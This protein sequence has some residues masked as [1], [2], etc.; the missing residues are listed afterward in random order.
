MGGVLLVKRLLRACEKY[1]NTWYNAHIMKIIVP[2]IKDVLNI[3][4]VQRY[5]PCVSYRPITF[6]VNNIIKEGMLLYNTLT[7]SIILVEYNENVHR[8]LIENWFFVP[9]DFDD[10]RFADRVRYCLRNNQKKEIITTYTIYPTTN[11]NAK[12]SYCFENGRTKVNMSKET[13][14]KVAKFIAQKSVGYNLSFRWF[15]GEPLLNQMAIDTICEALRRKNIIY[16]SKMATNGFLFEMSSIDKAVNLW[17]LKQVQITLDGTKEK[18]NKTKRYNVNTDA[19]EKVINNIQLLAQNGIS[20]NIRLNVDIVNIDDQI[21][22][23]TGVL[24]NFKKINNMISIYSHLL[25]DSLLNI[26]AKERRILLIKKNLIESEIADL[27]LTTHK[28]IQKGPKIFKCIADNKKSYTIMPMGQ[29][30]LCEHYTED[31]FISDINHSNVV[32]EHEIEN[33]RRYCNIMNLCHNCA[34]YPLCIRL[35]LCPD[36][37]YCFEELKRHNIHNIKI[38]MFNE[39]ERYTHSCKSI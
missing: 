6:L 21:S 29:I 23:V 8:Y 34:F 15:G 12:C 7:G 20:V 38:E 19:F 26:S 30:G 32:N 27:G 10:I 11:C 9:F 36:N 16:S 24:S 3:I 5:Q 14:I 2:G 18:Y 37:K 1:F 22:L 39:Y 17:N 28:G 25:I 4:G 33:I 31:R 13:A 35:E